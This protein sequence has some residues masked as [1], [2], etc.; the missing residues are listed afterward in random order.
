MK[1]SK[2]AV[3]VAKFVHVDETQL[4]ENHEFELSVAPQLQTS[5]GE[6]CFK[7]KLLEHPLKEVK[8]EVRLTKTNA[9]L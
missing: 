8:P 3:P 6:K 7:L 9:R 2:P 4:E 5:T 1:R